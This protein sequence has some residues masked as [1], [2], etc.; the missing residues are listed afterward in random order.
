MR[1]MVRHKSCLRVRWLA[2]FSSGGFLLVFPGCWEQWPR[3]AVD[4]GAG[5]VSSQFVRALLGSLPQ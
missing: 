4:F 3:Y 2:F 1:P 5:L